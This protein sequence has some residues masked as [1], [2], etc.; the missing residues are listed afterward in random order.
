[1]PNAPKRL[2]PKCGAIVSGRC[3]SCSKSTDKARPNASARG[4]TSTRWRRFR[5]WVFSMRPLCEWICEDGR[6]CNQPATDLDHKQRVTGPDDP[7]FYD[8]KEVQP[9]CHPHH[10]TK[11]ATERRYG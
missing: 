8:E 11:T 5:S 2:C 3:P 4:Y 10:S 9:L 6:P 1:M 7:R